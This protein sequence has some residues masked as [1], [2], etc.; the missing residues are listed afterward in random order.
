MPHF[1]KRESEITMMY[2]NLQALF[3]ACMIVCCVTTGRAQEGGYLSRLSVVQGETLRFYISTSFDTF[4]IGITRLGAEP[5]SVAR[6]EGVRGGVQAVRD[7]AYILG[8]DWKPTAS[9]I[10]PE[11][12]SSGV[13][14][15][16]FPTTEGSKRMIFVVRER[17]PAS[18]SRTLICLSSNTWQAYNNFGGKSL[19][20]FNST[21]TTASYKVSLDRP[22]TNAMASNYFKHTDKL[23]RW[24]EKEQMPAEFCMIDDLDRDPALLAHYD[25]LVIAGHSEYWSR[26]ERRQMQQLVDRGGRLIILGGNTC[27]WQVRFENDHRT[28]VCYKSAVADPMYGID[29]S[30]VTE[31]WSRDPIDEPEN[32]LIGVS[33]AHGG[34]VNRDS[35]LLWS[36]GNGG[37]TAYHADSWIF[38][39]T[40]V[41]DGDIFGQ[42]SSV[43][44]YEV[45]GALYRWSRDS[46][47]ELIG[48]DRTPRNF[49]I[50]GMAPA[51]SEAGGVTGAATLGYYT[52]ENGGA[53][54]NAAT[55][56]WTDG[57]ALGDTAIT[58]I[59]RNVFRQFTST[60]PFP[61]VVVSF[62]PRTISAD[63]IN[64][65]KVYL[66]HRSLTFNVC[67]SDT[68]SVHAVDPQNRP[69]SFEWRW[70]S[71]PIGTDSVCILDKYRKLHSEES[72]I[73]TCTISNGVTSTMIDWRFNDTAVA[74]TSFPKST[75]VGRSQWFNYHPKASAQHD[76]HPAIMLVKAPTWLKLD[77]FGKLTGLADTLPGSYPV[78]LKASDKHGRSSTQSFSI[79]V[80]EAFEDA[81]ATPV[82]S[83]E[84]SVVPNPFSDATA[85]SFTCAEASHA[86]IEL[87]DETGR[88]LRILC[89]DAALDVGLQRFVWDGADAHGS[90]VSHG[91][92]RVRV[93]L[94]TA[95]GR[96]IVHSLPTL[97]L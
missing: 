25:V 29:N 58:M 48:A 54:F 45:D 31:N 83:N 18:R 85:V 64:N 73:I 95:D 67:R 69:L 43:V 21:H 76:E 34:Y 7:S 33:F 65:Q 72:T 96:T 13:Y 63:S 94:R 11:T 75:V 14:E 28:M 27:W 68:L 61:P 1:P 5:R 2:R 15:A 89:H 35:L 36:N 81:R 4:S 78:T 80:V 59:T 74:F 47:L 19:Y 16:E 93:T 24:M 97:K 22:F 10:I 6:I 46:M 71:W 51:V 79:T 92:Y 44:G 42:R 49:Q 90:P 39:S 87:F 50:L 26:P 38:D 8:C 32:S 40:N 9:F 30:I 77:H 55:I 82:V 17:E 91:M 52:N 60:K 41:R 57:L 20:D 37:F 53:V 70:G 66:P 62:S 12:W 56:N 88:P 84:L 23:V 3:V 86:T